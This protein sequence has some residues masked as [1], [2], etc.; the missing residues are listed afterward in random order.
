MIK[1]RRPC[2]ATKDI[3]AIEADTIYDRFNE[4]LDDVTDQQEYTQNTSSKTMKSL[5]LARS[6]VHHESMRSSVVVAQAAAHRLIA[7]KSLREATMMS[8]RLSIAELW[9]AMMRL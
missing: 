6:S 4:H 7:R 5:H 3:R 1:M 8:G 9:D 2:L